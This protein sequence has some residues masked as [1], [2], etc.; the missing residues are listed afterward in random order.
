MCGA[1]LWLV[2]LLA[3]SLVLSAGRAASADARA[4]AQ[5]VPASTAPVASLEP[6]KTSALWAQLVS[7]RSL[8]AATTQC[9]PL[10]AVF[11]A[12][13]DWLRLATRLAATASPCAEYYVSIPPIV[14]DKT[15]PR[16][17]QAWRIRALGPRF[18]AL[19]EIHFATWSRWVAETGSSWHAAGVTARQRMAAAGYDVAQ[20]DSWVV[21]ELGTGVRRGLGNARANIREFLRGL[22]EGDGTQPAQGA[23]F[24]IGY[25]Q[26]SADVSVYQS[27]LQHW[28]TD[29]AFWSDMARYVADWSQEVY[30]D[31]RSHAVPGSPPETR[32]EYLN[33]YL[34]H[35][36][37]LAGAGPAEAGTARGYLRQAY[38]PLAN[39]AWQYDQ[40]YGWTA[41][42]PEQM[43]AYISAQVHA[44]REFSAASGQARDRW[45]FAWAPKNATG[46]SAAEFAAQTGFLLDRLAA[47]IRDSGAPVEPGSPGSGACGPPRL[48][49][50]CALD[51]EGAR[52]NLAW[53]S[54]RS[55]TTSGVGFTTPA[56]TAV[57][58]TPSNGIAVSLL[59]TTGART[60][61]GAAR[62]ATVR[63]SSPPGTFAASPA[64]PWAPT[65][66]VSV[67]AD[68]DPVVYYRD[69]K[70]GTHTITVT[71]GGSFSGTQQLVVRAGPAVR[72]KVTPG[73]GAVR[74][75]GARGF[76]AT[77]KDAYGNAAA[78]RLVW[79]VRPAGL[80]TIA[81]AGAGKATFQAERIVRRGRVSASIVSGARTVSGS[82]RVHVQPA[83]LRIDSLAHRR[84]EA[85]SH[86]VLRAVDAA[87][88]P[89]SHATVVA[90]VLRDG[91]RAA[92]LKARTGP[93]G[94]A[95]LPLPRVGGCVTVKVARA[96]AAGFF[97]D[98]R[99]P[100]TR[101]CT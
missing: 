101:V 29:S 93:A 100:S 71:A 72:V 15:Q 47:A 92:Q 70:A 45:G 5:A 78:G 69:P 24:V 81:P 85:G 43:A 38:S 9:R 67:P 62:A 7:S 8:S 55:W 61:T 23:A 37:L 58:G 99:G 73:T 89:V 50:W 68:P 3:L 34:Q 35:K 39:A 76:V 64:G 11:Y 94:H 22:Y 44:L 59:T 49:A 18:H 27:T 31:A 56:R 91:R 83:P 57:A 54:F 48:D 82:A 17:D 95:R 16:P 74:A 41:L 66:S 51:L 98:R 60:T 33:D 63:S 10:R 2:S 84:T 75:R 6:A 87:R 97:W 90:V 19:A 20:G 14:A 46:V 80:G 25:G 13:S 79:R 1:R 53:R 32:R 86:V 28:L 12:A 4:A 40:A 77:A 96:A 36:L 88:K 52:H 30:G 21:N 42:P 65:V 26:G